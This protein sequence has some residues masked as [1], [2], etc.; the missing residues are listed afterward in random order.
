MQ[1]FDSF[2]LHPSI[3]AALKD[4]GYETATPIQQKAIPQALFGEDVL[5]TAQTGTGKTAAFALPI[6]SLIHI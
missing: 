1:K 3:L 6:L 5:G 2:P 4:E